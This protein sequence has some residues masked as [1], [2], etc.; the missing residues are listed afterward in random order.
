MGNALAT[1]HVHGAIY[2]QRGLLTSDGKEIKNKPEIISLLSALHKPRKVSVVH[3]PSH[4]KGD[5]PIA[6]RN[7]MAN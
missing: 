1:A 6:R 2:E 3:C 7:N 4:Q 5:E